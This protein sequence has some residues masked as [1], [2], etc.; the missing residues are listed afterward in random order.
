MFECNWLPRAQCVSEVPQRFAK[1]RQVLGEE[2]A[3]T[4]KRRAAPLVHDIHFRKSAEEGPNFAQQYRS[5]K[6]HFLDTPLP[7]YPAITREFGYKFCVRDVKFFSPR[8]V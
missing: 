4:Q 6:T 1:V 7:S 3:S 8:Y 2:V 5:V